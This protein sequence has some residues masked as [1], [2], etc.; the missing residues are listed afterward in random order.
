MRPSRLVRHPVVALV[1]AAG[2]LGG[3]GSSAAD[4]ASDQ[5]C[6]A[7]DDIAKHV[8]KLE[9]L[10]ITTA[11]TDEVSA[12]LKAIRKDLGTIRGAKG[13]LS[14]QRREDVEAANTEF[15]AAMKDVA[16]AVGR[17][18]SI[19]AA[20]ADAKQATQQLA[21]TYKTSFGKLDCS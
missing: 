3:C 17:S 18:L 5:V 4:D 2:L 20:A 15:R 1:L 9:G 7:R 19:E 10:T 14:D 8:D 11:T 21:T 6:A 16:G 13:D 12:S